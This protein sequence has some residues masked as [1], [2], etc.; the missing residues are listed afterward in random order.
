MRIAEVVRALDSI[1]ARY[2]LIG[3]HAM[4]ARG[5]PRSTVDVDLL[6]TDARVLDPGVWS[7]L[8]RAGA[9][10]DCRRG[11]FDDPLAGAVHIRHSD[12]SEIDVIVGKWRWEARVVD[13]AEPLHVG[14]CDVPVARAG[15]LILLKLVAGGYLDLRDAAALLAT[16][17]RHAIVRDV[18]QHLDEVRPDVRAAWRELLSA[19][20]E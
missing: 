1:G 15:D 5:Y 10:V 17:D 7:D 12:G 6:T 2:A 11:D 4:A 13:R 3:A 8:L 20:P 9:I 19:M 16:G 18:E 14:G